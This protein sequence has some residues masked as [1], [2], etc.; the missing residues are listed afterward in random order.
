MATHAHGIA[1]PIEGR[2][3]VL[4]ALGDLSDR[5]EAGADVPWSIGG[6]DP[7]HV[8]ARWRGVAAFSI[9]IERFE[10][11]MKLS[12]NRPP[13]DRTR[14]AAALRARGGVDERNR[15]GD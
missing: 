1:T 12:Q 13:E 15:R 6:A 3:E 4:L 10:T 9:R 14:V 8:E 7:G 5:F 2:A 11:K